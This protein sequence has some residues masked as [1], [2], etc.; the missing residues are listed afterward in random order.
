MGRGGSPESEAAACT[1]SEKIA[2]S[3]I[4]FNVKYFRGES[5]IF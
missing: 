5:E 4:F 1:V 2:S 3:L